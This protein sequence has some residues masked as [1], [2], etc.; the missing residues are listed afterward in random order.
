MIEVE[1]DGQGMKGGD[2]D[3]KTLEISDLMVT[4]NDVTREWMLC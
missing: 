4:L 1:D 3:D 2:A